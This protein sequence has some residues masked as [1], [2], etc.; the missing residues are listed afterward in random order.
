MKHS[1]HF[2]SPILFALANIAAAATMF[3]STAIAQTQAPVALEVPAKSVPVPPTVS[4]EMQKII[5]L[6]LRTNWN[7]LPKT[8]EESSRWPRPAQPAPSRT[9]PESAGD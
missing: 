5:G 3:Q 9:F 6:P 8:G 4:P 1:S 7:V 2:G